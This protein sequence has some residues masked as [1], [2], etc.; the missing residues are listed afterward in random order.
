M[1]GVDLGFSPLTLSS[2][3]RFNFKNKSEEF[4]ATYTF[5]VS[6]KLSGTSSAL[7]RNTDPFPA[8]INVRQKIFIQIKPQ[9]KNT[10][11]SPLIS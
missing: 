1:V 2:R 3:P 4:Y 7:D 10:P 11:S 6:T 5:K 9:S 8:R